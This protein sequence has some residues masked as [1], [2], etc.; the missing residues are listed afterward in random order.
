M[1]KIVFFIS[2]IFL[3]TGCSNNPFRSG[4]RWTGEY[5]C[6]QGLTDL[7]LTIIEN[8][9][10]I[11]KAIFSFYHASSGVRGSFYMVG[12]YNAETREMKFSPTEWIERPYNYITVGMRGLVLRNPIRY[13]GIITTEG[14]GAFSLKLVPR[15]NFLEV[16][17]SKFWR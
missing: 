5:L 9:A 17:F 11:Q 1:K 6:R 14:C 7:E 10:G 8:K 15:R 2:A 4:T 16:F 12:E 13:E 3:L